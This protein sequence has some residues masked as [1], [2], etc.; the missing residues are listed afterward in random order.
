MLI[1]HLIDFHGAIEFGGKGADMRCGMA[2]YVETN[3]NGP[4][5]VLINFP[6]ATDT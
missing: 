4:P 5:V 1:R 6:R 2:K 3:G